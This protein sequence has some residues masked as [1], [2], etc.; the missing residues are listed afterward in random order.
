MWAGSQP[1]QEQGFLSGSGGGEEGADGLLDEGS[2]GGGVVIIFYRVWYGEGAC[3]LISVRFRR[4]SHETHLE[5]LQKDAVGCFELHV[6][7]CIR[8]KH[9]DG[10][11][12]NDRVSA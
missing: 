12:V 5:V 7:D 6:K 11:K 2:G 10:S 4:S 8:V 3:I 9:L 1:R